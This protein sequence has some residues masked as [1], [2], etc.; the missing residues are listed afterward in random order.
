MNSAKVNN[1]KLLFS[2]LMYF[3]LDYDYKNNLLQ[4]DLK[5][6]NF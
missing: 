3:L 6:A 1:F 5:N 2:Y 4:F